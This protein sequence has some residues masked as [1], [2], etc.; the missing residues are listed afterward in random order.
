M[1]DV[2]VFGIV[3]SLYILYLDQLAHLVEIW[4]LWVS[5]TPILVDFVGEIVNVYT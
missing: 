5:E 3:I 2:V 4:S 1:K